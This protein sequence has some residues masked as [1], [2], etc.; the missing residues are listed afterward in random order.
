M[1]RRAGPQRRSS[2]VASGATATSGTSRGS[3]SKTGITARTRARPPLSNHE[4]GGEPLE[5]PEITFAE[6]VIDNGRFGTRTVRFETGRLAKQAAGSAVVYLDGET[7]LLSTTAAGK[8]PKDQ[9][10]FFPLTVDVEERMYAAGRIPGSF[11]RREGR[12]STDAIL[13]C[14]L[15]DRPLRPTLRQGPAQRGPGRRHGARA[16]P[17]RPLRRR[18]HQRR[19]DVDPARRPAVQ[20]PDRR[21]PRRPHRG[22]VGRLPA[23]Q[24]AR[25]RRLRHGRRRPHRDRRRRRRGR[26]DHDG[27][28]RG[29]GRRVAP[30]QG[31]ERAGARPRRSSPR[32]SRPPSRSSPR[33]CRA[34]QQIAA[35]AAKPT[36]EFPLFPD[37]EQDVYDVVEATVATELAQALA[38]A[39][40]QEREARIDELKDFVKSRLAERLRRPREGDLGGL[41]GGAE[42]AGPAAD[43]ARQGPHRRPRPGGHPPA[44]GRGRGRPAG[45]RLGAVRA[46]R[47]ADPRRHDAEHAPDGAA[48][49]HAVAGDP[50]ALHAQLQLPALQHRRDRP[51]RARRS[52]ARSATARSPSGPSCRC[53]RRREEFPYA[54]RQVSEAL[55]LE[56]LD[57]DGLGLRLDPV[58]AQRRCAAARAGRGHRHGPGLRH[59]RRRDRVR[60]ADRHPR[61]RGRVRRHGLQG[62]RHLG[63][64]HRDPARHQARRHPGVRARRGAHPGPRRPAAHPR[65]HGR[66]H[67][68]A[69]R[70]VAVRAARH[71]R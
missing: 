61:R 28:G 65:R 55:E 45:A 19:L 31:R 59:R 50:Q 23:A 69:G 12:P 17:R 57:V 33:S 3:R 67:R 1:E 13:T 30:R 52:G 18:R 24:R 42:E 51:R 40:K 4:N 35:S 39:G 29:D 14:R 48:A 38:I 44:L 62:R 47:D 32:A 8:Q 9:F 34:Q 64:R 16:E 43:P 27:R 71:Q 26:R 6:A 20:R 58:A 46:R 2:T 60:R 25:A 66:G 22:P 56:R 37:Y 11:F 53:C 63:V 36:A 54:I 5:G 21:R 70:D 7:M 15:I 41:P 68:P 10:D 49:R